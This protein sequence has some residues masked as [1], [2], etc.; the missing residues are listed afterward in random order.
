MRLIK[1]AVLLITTFVILTGFK[2]CPETR[3]YVVKLEIAGCQGS[4]VLTKYGL[5]SAAHLFVNK[6][7][8]KIILAAKAIYSDHS[9]H[10]AVL[11]K[12]DTITDLALLIP[13]GIDYPECDI[14]Q[15]S[16][17]NGD[18]TTIIGCG[19]HWEFAIRGGI[20]A[21]HTMADLSLDARI[22]PGDSGGGV[23]NEDGDLAGIIQTVTL[24]PVGDTSVPGFG[25]CCSTE[26]L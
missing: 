9:V 13:T 12:L 16:P 2:I 10:L 18:M 22:V 21:T 8:D 7:G 17:S 5:L 4:G 26:R 14:A 25:S 23:F 11:D 20:V 3:Q 1:L 15:K 6:S 24:V 19:W